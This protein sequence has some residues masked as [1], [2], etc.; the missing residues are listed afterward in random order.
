ME[1]WHNFL[2][3]PI[4]T[5]SKT[6]FIRNWWI[7]DHGRVKWTYNH[8]DRQKFISPKMTGG[9]ATSGRY[10]ALSINNAPEKYIHRLV[11]RYFVD[12][13]KGEATV[14]HIDGD[15][16]NNHYTNLEWISYRDNSIHGM[17]IRGQF[18]Q[19]RYDR[20]KALKVIRRTQRL[21]RLQGAER[22]LQLHQLG[23][24]AKDIAEITGFSYGVVRRD[25][26][27][28]NGK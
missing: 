19:Q 5:K 26:R 17:K 3:A 21:E 11:A 14:N 4:A 7:S 18:D 8:N 6:E 1:N 27:K 25:I 22:H 2:S 23:V 10:A 28:A 16:L 24:K 13:P 9:H 15:K 12:N 20:N